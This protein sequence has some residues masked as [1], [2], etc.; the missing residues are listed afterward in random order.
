[1]SEIWL[2]MCIDLYVNYLS[3][4]SDLNEIW[5]FPDRISKNTQIS[6][7]M[8]I[9][10]VKSS[11]FMRTDERTDRQTDMLKL[12][13]TFRNEKAPTNRQTNSKIHT[14]ETPGSHVDQYDTE[15]FRFINVRERWRYSSERRSKMNSGSFMITENDLAPT[16]DLQKTRKRPA[17]ILAVLKRDMNCILPLHYSHISLSYPLLAL[18]TDRMLT[19]P[20]INPTNLATKTNYKSRRRWFDSR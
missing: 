12:V 13:V 1:M 7:F 8:K 16:S 14:Q 5:K 11:C 6:N 9:R 15:S 18:I 20:N 4:L 10:P 2:K 17:G 19:C 3:F